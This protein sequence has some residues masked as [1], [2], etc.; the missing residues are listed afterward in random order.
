MAVIDSPE[1]YV[2]ED[3]FIDLRHIIGRNL[4]LKCEGLNLAGSIKLK[5][6]VAMV[7]AAELSGELNPG[8]GVVESS[9]GN[10]GVALSLVCASRGH[11]F[12]C[13]TDIRCTRTSQDVMR[14]LGAQVHVITEPSPEG[15][16]L[17]ARLDQVHH[18]CRQEGHL[19]LNQYANDA[20][21][22]AHY[23]TTAPAISRAF[24]LL[25]VLFIGAGTTGTLMGCARFF[26]EHRPKTKIVAI[27]TVGSV[28]FG[29]EPGP[30]HI[31]GLGTGVRPPILDVSL[32]DDVVHVPEIDAIGASRMLVRRGFLLGGS[33]GTVVAGAL[34]WMEGADVPPDQVTAA[35]SPDLGE[36]Y[37]ETIYRDEWV[38]ETYG[39][40][41]AARIGS[42]VMPCFGP[43][44]PEVAHLLPG[45]AEA[46][47][48]V[49]ASG[50][51]LAPSS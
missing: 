22:L 32:V 3:V 35:V 5:S 6:A 34:S 51:A 2:P 20:N 24:P 13:V 11:R 33:T 30:R 29:G 9:S 46:S 39:R 8:R 27:D 48:L 31:P 36:R 7:D 41:A 16:L 18:L 23:R 17:G 45:L 40:E 28:N 26:R 44:S 49:V 42:T 15:G 47:D 37:S 4:F 12:T 14:A 50:N 43:A 21:W 1:H 10:M 25:D 38:V 19:W